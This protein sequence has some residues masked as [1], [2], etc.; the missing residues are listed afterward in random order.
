MSRI[1]NLIRRLSFAYSA[2]LQICVADANLTKLPFNNVGVFPKLADYFVDRIFDVLKWRIVNNTFTVIAGGANRE[3]FL[4]KISN[5][6]R[7]SN[8][9]KLDPVCPLQYS[10]AEPDRYG[11]TSTLIVRFGPFENRRLAIY[12]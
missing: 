5:F 6:V 9:L 3:R 1:L 11:D 10:R 7:N 4:T 8:D 12:I 2:V